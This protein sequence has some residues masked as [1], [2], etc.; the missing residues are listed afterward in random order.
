[1]ALTKNNTKVTNIQEL[2]DIVV[3]QATTVKALFDKSNTDI[4]TYINDTLTVEL[5]ALDATNVKKTGDQAIIGVKTFSS[6]PIVPTPTTDMQV[7]NK[8]YVLSQ[9]P[10]SIE[11]GSLTDLKLSNAAGDIKGRFSTHLAERANIKYFGAHSV[12][13]I[14][15]ENFDSTVAIQAAVDSL[16]LNTINLVT[17]SPKGFANGGEVFIPRGRYKITGTILLKRGIQIVGLSRESSQFLSFNTGSVFKYIDSGTYIQDEIGV[18]NCSIW[19]D[20]SVV[21]TSGAAI[22]IASDGVTFES[23]YWNI[24]NVLIE[25]TYYG[26]KAMGGIGCAVRNSN[27]SKCVKSN[28]ILTQERATTSTVFENT[29]CHISGDSGFE[30]QSSL[31]GGKVAAFVNF[32]GCAADSSTNYGYKIGDGLTVTFTACGAECNGIA[33]CKFDDSNVTANIYAL[34]NGTCGVEVNACSKLTFVG[35]YLKGT[36][37]Y[38]INVTSALGS[39]TIVGTEFLDNYATNKINSVYKVLNL[40]DDYGLVGGGNNWAIGV[41]QQPDPD[42]VFQ[43]AGNAGAGSTTGLKAN[44]FFTGAGAT[45][46]SALYTQALTADTVVTYPQ[47]IGH[48]LANAYKGVASFVTKSAGLWIVEQTKGTSANANIMIAVAEASV[49]NGEWNVYSGSAKDSLFKGNLIFDT[50]GK[51]VIVKTP[52][53]TKKYRIGVDNAGALTSTLIP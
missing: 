26:I 24:D 22:E 16:P 4:K 36:V 25:G 6:S 3:D 34:N 21:P 17:L 37:G 8:A 9:S 18:K 33:A 23:N 7:A 10:L 53:G 29:Y 19:Q 51:G 2:A 11:N 28:I 47:L 31:V 12:D 41:T 14:G 32:I 5:D 45:R 43:V 13:E 42:S 30:I 52:D 50:V 39:I 40:S 38:G 27:I 35:G 20:V 46:N 1:M 48:F 49:P 15:Y 44:V